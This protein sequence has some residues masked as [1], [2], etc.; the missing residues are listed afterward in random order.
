MKKHIINFIVILLLLISCSSNINSSNSAKQLSDSRFNGSFIYF[1]SW[2]DINGIDENY[3][4]YSYDFDG[5]NKFS[6]W[7][8]YKRYNKLDGWSY[9]SNYPNFNQLDYEIE[10]N[11][12]KTMFRKRL[13]DNEYAKWNDWKRYEFI[14]DE[15][16]LRIYESEISY[17]DYIKE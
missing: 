17:K 5:T 6:E 1:D 11:S 14:D 9:S 7:Y 13:W 4:Y 15:Q 10:I 8:K 12:D 3:E 2:K 16:T